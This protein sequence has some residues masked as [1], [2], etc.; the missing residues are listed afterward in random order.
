[1]EG[2]ARWRTVEHARD[3]AADDRTDDADDHR[4]EEAHRHR[5]GEEEAREQPDDEA[6][7]DVPKNVQHGCSPWVCQVEKALSCAFSTSRVRYMSRLAPD[8]SSALRSIG[9]G[10][11]MARAGRMFSTPG[12]RCEK[13][14]HCDGHAAGD[15]LAARIRCA[16]P[17]RGHAPRVLKSRGFS[18]PNR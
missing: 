11:S 4:H 17:N 2:R 15:T 7:D 6:D 14:I 12:R 16:Q 10:S 5:A 8:Q 9:G 13:E 1:M 18:P 3:Q